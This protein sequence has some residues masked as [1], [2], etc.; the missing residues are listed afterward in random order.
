[1]SEQK[2]RFTP[3]PWAFDDTDESF[4][5]PA[6]IAKGAERY[7]KYGPVCLVMNRHPNY[8]SNATLIA[9]APEMYEFIKSL[10]SF[11]GQIV[12]AT[13]GEDGIKIYNEAMRVLKKAMGEA[14]E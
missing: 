2:E 14:A 6:I 5:R 8:K 4:G 7:S 10:T 11:G 9:A 3:V 1:M 13:L 12:L